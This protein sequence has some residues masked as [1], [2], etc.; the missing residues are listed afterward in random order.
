MKKREDLISIL[1]WVINKSFELFIVL[2]IIIYKLFIS[3]KE[4]TLWNILVYGFIFK[5]FEFNK[6]ISIKKNP[7]STSKK[8]KFHY[9]VTFV[10]TFSRFLFS[11][12]KEIFLMGVMEVSDKQY[13]TRIIENIFTRIL[14]I[15][16]LRC[17]SFFKFL[18]FMIKTIIKI[19]IMVFLDKLKPNGNHKRNR[20]NKV[21]MKVV[22]HIYK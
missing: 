21:G 5:Q 13:L 10:V 6:K 16:Y 7:D 19:R 11:I 8:I 9:L 20:S 17:L 15:I 22:R 3:M 2:F 18:G 1:K 4:E 12:I 14:T